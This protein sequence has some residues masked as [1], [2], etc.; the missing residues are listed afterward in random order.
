[1][2]P[3][4]TLKEPLTYAAMNVAL[5]PPPPGAR[6]KVSAA[7]AWGTVAQHGLPADQTGL[8]L[9]LFTSEFPE[10]QT[11]HGFKSEF[12]RTLAWVVTA[13][14]LIS[15]DQLPHPPESSPP[16]LPTCLPWGGL[17]AVDATTGQ[18]LLSIGAGPDN[19]CLGIADA[20]LNPP[21][22]PKNL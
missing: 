13:E 2:P 15:S 14:G 21:R 17:S 4:R 3:A 6:P 18:Q 19:V 22:C 9:A 16:A 1:M 12:V 7:A 10:R 11:S 5:Q 8:V 20:Y